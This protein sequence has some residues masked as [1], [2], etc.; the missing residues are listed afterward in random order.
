MPQ[1]PIFL[2]SDHAGFALKK[3]CV[4]YFQDH[5]V[6]CEDLGTHTEESCDYPEFAGAVCQQ[7]LQQSG[8]GVLVCGTGLGMSMTA[9]RFSNIRAALCAN[10]YQAR[11]ARKHNNS[12]VLCLGSRVLGEDLALGILQAFLNTDFEGERHQRR[13]ERMETVVSKYSL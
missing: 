3:I 8:L 4:R 6:A 7:V 2:G 13:I 11:M 1:A 10:E 5:N 9:N 12:N